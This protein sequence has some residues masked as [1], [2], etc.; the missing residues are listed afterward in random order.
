M[1]P[2]CL[3]IRKP[4]V[5]IPTIRCLTNRTEDQIMHMIENGKLQFAWNVAADR[6]RRQCVRVLTLSVADFILGTKSQPS[7][8]ADAIKYIFPSSSEVIRA[9]TIARMLDTSPTHVTALVKQG[10]LV[11]AGNRKHS[12]DTDMICRASTVKFMTLRRIP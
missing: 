1:N 12:K 10:H 3:Q 11:K 8:I 7:E 6:A 5:G 2:P 9:S 4:L